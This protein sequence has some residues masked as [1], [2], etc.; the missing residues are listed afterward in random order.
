MSP[1]SF[2]TLTGLSKVINNYLNLDDEILLAEMGAR[3]VGDI[4]ELCDLIQ[5]KY[6]IITSVGE[7]HLLTFKNFEN[8]LK[9][10]FEL[11]EA[12]PKN[13]GVAVFNGFDKGAKILYNRCQLDKKKITGNKGLVNAKNITFDQMGTS[14]DLLINNKTYSAKTVLLGKHNVENIVLC[15][16]MAK[17]LGLSDKEI[18]NGISALK[19]IPHRLE[20]IKTET[21]IILDDSYNASVEGSKVALNA[22]SKMPGRKIVITPGLV[23]MGEKEKQANIDL[24]KRIAKVA[25]FVIIVNKVNFEAIKQGL[26]EKKFKDENIYQAETLDKAKI[27]MRD[28]LSTGDSILFENDLPDNYI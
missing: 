7:Q 12:L 6:G 15:V 18:L 3:Q 11:I 13:E 4:K 20:L 16:Q 1:H 21:N 9:T 24:G 17:I 8:V 28:F 14:F 2:N 23:E 10:K 19:P 26:D 5:P 22:L 27:L 25:D